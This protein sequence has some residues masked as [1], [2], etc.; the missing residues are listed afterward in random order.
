MKYKRKYKLLSL[1]FLGILLFAVSCKKEKH[2]PVLTKATFT[3]SLKAHSS[4]PFEW[5]SIKFQNSSG[6]SYGVN[7][8]NFYISNITLKKGDGKSFSSKKIYY[9]DPSMI[10]KSTFLLDSI[11]PGTYTEMSFLLGL[12]STRN[13][14]HA[15]PPTTDNMNMAWPDFMGGGYHFLK[16]EGHFL[17]TIGAE[18]GFA[19]HL[20]KNVNLPTVSFTCAMNQ[21]YWDHKYDLTFD[22][23]EIFDHPYKYDLNFENNYT[24]SDSVA[25]SRIKNN[26]ADA[27]SINQT[28]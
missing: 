5:D 26:L 16:F 6:N 14:T 3:I 17:D 13:K 22:L 18:N 2:P 7:A 10:S 8:L 1:F 15:L 23:N 21:K 4:L 28:H 9:I 12:D 20:G 25:M 19:I 27:F 11:P 24:M